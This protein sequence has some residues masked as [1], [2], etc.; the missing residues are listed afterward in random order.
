[1][2]RSPRPAGRRC[3]RACSPPG[4]SIDGTWPM[5]TERATGCIAIGTNALA[6]SIV[7]VCRPRPADAGITT[8]KDFVASPQARD[9]RGAADAPAR[10]HR[11][12]GPRPG[13]DR[14]GDGGLQPLREGARARRLGD[15]R[16]H[17]ARAHQPGPRR[18]PRRA[19]GR[20]RRRHP[21]G[22]RLVRAVRPRRVG[23]RDRGD[24][25]EGEEQLGRRPRRGR[26]RRR[27]AR[28]RAPPRPRRVHAPT[29]IPRR[30]RASPSG[31]RPSASSTPC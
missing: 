13:V 16:P 5:R 4:F 28:T 11:A 9:A 30:T 29:G 19:G 26:H 27:V 3:S 23:V 25:V 31:R 20:V 6:S 24:A 2:A 21:L 10:Q 22:D 7:L 8:R 1:M 15:A 14:A 17:R 18:D 12:G